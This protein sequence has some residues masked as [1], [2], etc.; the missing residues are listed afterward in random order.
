MRSDMNF[1]MILKSQC[2]IN[3]ERYPKKRKPF[4]ISDKI[5]IVYKALIMHEKHADI[6]KEYRVRPGVVS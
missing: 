2:P 1:E 4:S 3:Q 6:A 5:D